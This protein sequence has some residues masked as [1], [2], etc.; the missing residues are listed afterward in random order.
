MTD[1]ELN[2]QLSLDVS[3]KRPDPPGHV[4]MCERC[5]DHAATF[6]DADPVDVGFDPNRADGGGES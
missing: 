1:S 3:G 2:G 4:C 6:D 5:R